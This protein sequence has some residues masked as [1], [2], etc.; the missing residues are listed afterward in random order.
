MRCEQSLTSGRRQLARPPLNCRALLRRMAPAVQPWRRLCSPAPGER[1]GDFVTTGNG[2]VWVDDIIFC[3][4][5][6]VRAHER[7]GTSASS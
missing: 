6:R 5:V 1:R 4:L 3:K 2:V 7:R